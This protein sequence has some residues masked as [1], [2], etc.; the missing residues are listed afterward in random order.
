M[1]LEWQ[2]R[3]EVGW[4]GWAWEEAL[5]ERVGRGEKE[6]EGGWDPDTWWEGF[7]IENRQVAE[8][9]TLQ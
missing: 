6:K 5:G 4:E 8:N 2:G 9:E 3:T 1:W 7:E